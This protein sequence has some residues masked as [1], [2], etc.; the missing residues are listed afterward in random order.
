[1]QI[2]SKPTY[3]QEFSALVRYLV[4]QL[5]IF[6]LLFVQRHWRDATVVPSDIPTAEEHVQRIVAGYSYKASPQLKQLDAL[7][8]ESIIKLQL[9]V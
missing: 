9:G 8:S 7:I 5:G 6:L 2:Q 1:M 4:P 3:M